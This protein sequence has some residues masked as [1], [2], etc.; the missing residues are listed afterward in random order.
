MIDLTKLE[1]K[2][3]YMKIMEE[4]QNESLRLMAVDVIYQ[5]EFKPGKT[6]LLFEGPCLGGGSV[7]TS[8]DISRDDW[9]FLV[10]RPSEQTALATQINIVANWF[11]ELKRLVPTGKK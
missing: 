7:A 5:P 1:Q 11:E 3:L 6:R 8:Y 4:I 10:I 2:Q 9:L